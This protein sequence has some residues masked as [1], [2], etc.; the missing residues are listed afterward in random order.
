MIAYIPRE[1]NFY[2][3]NEIHKWPP[4]VTTYRMQQL[5]K[6]A[7]SSLV[8]AQKPGALNGIRPQLGMEKK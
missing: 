1:K 6:A 7:L 3:N 5:Y 4:D 2:S 8:D